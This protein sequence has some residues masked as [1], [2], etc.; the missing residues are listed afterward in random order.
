MGISPRCILTIMLIA[1]AIAPAFAQIQLSNYNPA[2]G[3]MV[4]FNYTT[5]YS[6]TSYRYLLGEPSGAYI[7]NP[8]YVSAT[9]TSIN[10]SYSLINGSIAIP[11]DANSGTYYFV[12]NE[13]RW[14]S[15]SVDSVKF[16]VNHDDS[17]RYTIYSPNS[18]WTNL[19][20]NDSA[21]QTGE[22]PFADPKQFADHYNTDW[23]N[24]VIYVRKVINLDNYTEASLRF[25]AE[26]NVQC[27][28][29]GQFIGQQTD[30]VYALNLENCYA[31][32][33]NYYTKNYGWVE[34]YYDD[35]YD[36]RG[37][38]DIEI[39]K[40][41]KPGQNIIACKAWTEDNVFE[42]YP[43][44]SY[45]DVKFMPL[46]KDD[47]Q[48]STSTSVRNYFYKNS[49]AINGTYS[50]YSCKWTTG[51][52]RY[53]SFKLDPNLNSDW[54]WSE[55]PVTDN[56]FFFGDPYHY[57]H[58]FDSS[59]NNL[60]IGEVPYNGSTTYLRTWFW[61]DANGT[62]TLKISD[63]KIPTCYLN[64]QQLNLSNYNHAY[65]KYSTNVNL[66]QGLNLLACKSA[67]ATANQFD[68]QIA[69]VNGQLKITDVLVDGDSELIFT[70]IIENAN[71]PEA[72][73]GIVMQI[74]HENETTIL[75]NS[76][77]SENIPNVFTFTNAFKFIPKAA[78]NYSITIIVS[79]NIDGDTDTYFSNI[80]LANLP[81]EQ[82]IGF[83]PIA[84]SSSDKG[85]SGNE[86]FIIA[87]AVIA[88]VGALA[89][90]YLYNP[91]SGSL[92][93]SLNRIDGSLSRASSVL[94][95]LSAMQS[96]SALANQNTFLSSI[97]AK[98]GQFKKHIAT[99]AAEQKAIEEEKERLKELEKK[100][101]A[102]YRN[103]QLAEMM[104]AAEEKPMTWAEWYAQQGVLMPD[105]R[106]NPVIFSSSWSAIAEQE[107][108][109]AMK[110][111][112]EQRISYD[113]IYDQKSF[114]EKFTGFFRG[115][116][117]YGMI[118]WNRKVDTISNV[119]TS[120]LNGDFIGA[121]NSGTRYLQ[122]ETNSAISAVKDNWQMIAGAAL[123]GAGIAVTAG[124]I[125][126]GSGLGFVLASAGIGM[127]TKRAVDAYAK[128]LNEINDFYEKDSYYT[129]EGYWKV[130]ENLNADVI[131][132][133]AAGGS[134]A[135]VAGKL[136]P[137][138]WKNAYEVDATKLTFGERISLTN[139]WNQWK[140]GISIAREFPNINKIT[141]VRGDYVDYWGRH[142]SNGNIRLNFQ[143]FYQYPKAI[144]AT[145]SH[146]AIEN[147]IY[148]KFSAEELVTRYGFE[149]YGKQETIVESLNVKYMDN[150]LFKK[151]FSESVK[152]DTDNLKINMENGL[153][154]L[155]DEYIEIHAKN[156]AV[157]KNTNYNEY[158]KLKSVL[159]KLNN[160]DDI[161]LK[162]EEYN[163][164]FNTDW[165]FLIG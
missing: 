132:F 58:N 110:Q 16:N 53:L 150:E 157:L 86:L 74:D 104:K 72:D 147:I 92:S 111:Q 128:P 105:N 142:F 89:G 84:G 27:W 160:Y 90:T 144:P 10:S 18:N 127:I 148:K 71:H 143:A 41:L 22:T 101:E 159:S 23:H 78:G 126:I 77:K 149:D 130:K 80:E 100:A 66:K 62:K 69:E 85:N 102:N 141:I 35:A 47:I 33:G 73:L 152:A 61:S 129:N 67:S 134:Y 94:A 39:S 117:K 122:E 2:P 26:N 51:N 36:Y 106:K 29:N 6:Y 83:I 82:K 24:D 79:D 28:V 21:W 56:S 123:V 43:G 96:S 95:A 4:Y 91:N 88:G 13:Y 114:G 165:S 133:A 25:M 12:I 59:D 153:T 50:E 119:A 31:K 156:L 1:I 45:L 7:E 103:Q 11:Q 15:E 34:L 19:T 60:K 151:S 57:T 138:I 158:L 70:P 81:A 5:K 109:K 63:T 118:D 108:N 116:L 125:G 98:Y 75:S 38:Q 17:W 113:Q 68:Y 30:N 65:W 76:Y 146:E 139:Q 112:E 87:G 124:T 32:T 120:L 14:P 49:F 145:V 161:L 121:W 46:G 37:S 42:K 107:K 44:R 154:Y 136:N 97:A 115:I 155:P 54:R 8:S 48:W 9:K 3:E 135:G 93:R 164:V 64:E 137:M 52:P 163:K 40:Y 140:P 162:L 55:K 99:I 131:S 20:F